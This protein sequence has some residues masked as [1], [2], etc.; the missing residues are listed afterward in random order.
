MRYLYHNGRGL[1]RTIGMFFAPDLGGKSGSEPGDSPSGG[2]T[3]LDV[4]KLLDGIP[5]DE[6]DTKS[7]EQLTKLQT[8]VKSIFAMLQ[9]KSIDSPENAKLLEQARTQARDFQSQKDQLEAKLRAVLGEKADLDPNQLTDEKYLKVARETLKKAGYKAEEIETHA[10][11]YADLLK[12]QLE[13]FKQDL[14]KDFQPM[15]GAVVLQQAKSAF[16]EACEQDEFG[17]MQVPEVAQEVWIQVQERAG[18]GGAVNPEFVLSLGKIAWVNHS[19]KLKKDNKTI[20]ELTPR[21]TGTPN[22]N[23]GVFNFPGA[24][25][26]MPGGG[27]IMTPAHDPNTPKHASNPETD[28][29]VTAT[30]KHIHTSTGVAPKH[31]KE[32]FEAKRR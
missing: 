1:F 25:R 13:I 16:E 6:L 24:G 4:D 28:A 29:A 9:S 32:G 21:T 14:G 11:L 17:V 19:A 8:S 23:T 2:A 22:V 27:P 5:L 3:T 15:V 31:L 10:K 26:S 18:A 12:G 20:P 30:F 7:R